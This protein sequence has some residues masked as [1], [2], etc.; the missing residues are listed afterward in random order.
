M[1]SRFLVL[2]TASFAALALASV[3]FA[4][5]TNDALRTADQAQ[6]MLAK[7]VAAVKADKATALDMFNKGEGGFQDGDLYVSCFKYQ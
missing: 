4:Q 3:A 2:A 7:A 6:A 5:T 1:L